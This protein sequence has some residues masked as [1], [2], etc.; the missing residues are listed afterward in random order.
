LKIGNPVLGSIAVTRLRTQ[1]FAITCR[2]IIAGVCALGIWYSWNLARADYLF[3]LDTEESVRAAIRIEPDASGYYMRLAQFDEAHAQQLLETSINLNLYNAQ[4]YIELGLRFEATGE[5]AR[6]EKLLL[7]AFAID[8]TF[9]P[10][11]SLANFYFRRD[12]MPA[13]WAWARRAAEMPSDSMGPL[14]ELCWRVSPDP[15]DIAGRIL[16]NNPDLIRQYTDFLLAKNEFQGA[17]EAARRL[18]QNGSPE[19]DKDE[20][21]SVIDRLIEA[22]DG[23]LAKALWSAL[24]GKQWVVADAGAPN[25]PNF[26]RDP[27]PLG[28]DWALPSYSGLHSS[29]GPSG[30][31]T[32]FS[33][34]QPEDCTVANQAVVLAPGKYELDYAYRTEGIPPQTGLRW[35]IIASG[36]DTPLAESPDLSSESQSYGKVVFSVPPDLSLFH[37]RLQYRR[38]L[39]TTRISGTLVIPSIQILPSP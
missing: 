27:L 34:E 38:A 2:T 28:F 24:I 11:W 13:F 8:H 36:S 21:F 29:T 30:L 15:N 14:F 17:A 23:D 10:R 20:I 35:Q 37:L 1:L 31:E 32:E 26:A 7:Q 18:V 3:R 9:M 5:Y 39:G 25:N 22:K 6:A 12:N 4:A 33:G 19:M 16:N